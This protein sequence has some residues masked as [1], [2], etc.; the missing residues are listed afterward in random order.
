[1]WFARVLS[2]GLRSRGSVAGLNGRTH[3]SRRIG[4]QIERLPIQE[5][6]RAA[7]RFRSSSNASPKDVRRSRRG[8]MGAACDWHSC[9]QVDGSPRG[10]ADR[11]RRTRH[12]GSRWRGQD[13][14]H[15]GSCRSRDR[16]AATTNRCRR[17]TRRMP[18]RHPPSIRDR[19]RHAKPPGRPRSSPRLP[20]AADRTGAAAGACHRSSPEP[21]G[22]KTPAAEV[23]SVMSQ[24]K[25]LRP[26]AA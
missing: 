8:A 17:G 5:W 16:P 1:M 24:R 15:R 19:H 21:T 23:C 20:E 12:R 22:R 11:R 18:V 4:T 14:I 7:K 3:D 10:P 2:V 25:D 13:A 9:G 26:A 6:W